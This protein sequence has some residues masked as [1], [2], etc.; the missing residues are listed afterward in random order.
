MDF[1]INGGIIK[2]LRE[3][4]NISQT[5][6]VEGIM[7]RENLSRF[8]SGEQGIK[9]KHLD[10]IINRLGISSMQ[11]FA[12]P[13]TEGE[14]KVHNIRYRLKLC[15]LTSDMDGVNT[16]ITEIEQIDEFKKG[17]LRQILIKAKA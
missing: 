6:L 4:Q 16:L 17:L 8:E 15:I 13:I 14:F 2:M 1:Q 10:L 3:E 12:Y 11:F 7:S 9:K 5:K